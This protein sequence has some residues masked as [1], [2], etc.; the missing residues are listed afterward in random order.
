[1]ANN[2]FIE[3]AANAMSAVKTRALYSYTSIVTA[4]LMPQTAFAGGTDNALDS[5]NAGKY[6]NNLIMIL[7]DIFRYVGIALFVWGVVQ[8]I[9]AVKRTDA[10]S[11]SDAIQTCLAGIALIAI[12]TL[13][14]FLGLS[15]DVQ[16]ITMT[17]Q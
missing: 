15:T 4:L 9:L 17:H 6:I 2:R 14:T 13:V 3:K 7:C 11:K 8:F 5:S 1:M 10:E 12:K 16:E